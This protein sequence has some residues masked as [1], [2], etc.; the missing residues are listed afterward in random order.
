MVD[1]NAAAL[2][3]ILLTIF[4][5]TFQIPSCKLIFMKGDMDDDELTFIR[6]AA[7]TANVLRF[8]K[9]DEKQPK[10]DGERDGSATDQ[11]VGKEKDHL[12]Y[13]EHR[14]RD[15]REFERRARGK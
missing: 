12:R 8:L 13:L 9:L 2:T 4:G 3:E 7:V 14:V 1:V 6:L 11:S 10:E 15:L 5:S